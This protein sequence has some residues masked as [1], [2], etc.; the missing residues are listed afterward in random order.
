M[1]PRFFS[2]ASKALSLRGQVHLSIILLILAFLL[3]SLLAQSCRSHK[4]VY[5]E[6]ESESSASSVTV[7]SSDR[8]FSE[9]F[10]QSVNLSADSIIFFFPELSDQDLLDLSL[11]NVSRGDSLPAPS[12]SSRDVHLSSHLNFDPLIFSALQKAASPS[13]KLYGVNYNN[14]KVKDSVESVSEVVLDESE[15]SM[16]S[17]R[18]EESV[19]VVSSNPPVVYWILLAGIL[20]AIIFLFRRK[21]SGL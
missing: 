5:T 4:E 18:A 19:K 12:R 9:R 14:S 16:S 10:R 6:S 20:F 8:L 13:V 11:L 1:K 2:F 3:L 7:Q 15:S 21:T 17:S